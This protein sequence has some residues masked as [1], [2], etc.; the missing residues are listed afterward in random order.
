[1]ATYWA[2]VA[3]SVFLFILGMLTGWVR[4]LCVS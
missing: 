2:H 1:V 3:V 4:S